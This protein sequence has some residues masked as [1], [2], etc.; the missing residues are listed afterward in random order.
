M[1]SPENSGMLDEYHEFIISRNIS[2]KQ[3]NKKYRSLPKRILK[4]RLFDKLDDNKEYFLK[5]PAKDRC[6]CGFGNPDA[7]YMFGYFSKKRGQ[8]NV[9]RLKQV[10]LLMQ[11]ENIKD[12]A[13]RIYPYYSC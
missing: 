9:S 6:Y 13:L 8:P 3:F 2:I 5:N 7:L 11:R 1:D 4:F 10:K 12:I